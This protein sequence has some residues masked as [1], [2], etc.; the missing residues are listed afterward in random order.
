M[1]IEQ[2][3]TDNSYRNIHYLIACQETGQALAID[4]LEHRNL[5]A[6][7]KYKDVIRRL[8]DYLPTHHEPD[9]PRNPH[10]DLKKSKAKLNR[11]AP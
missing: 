11:L 7:P 9:S 6:D 8:R 3:W 10:N 1:I 4:P 5:A 2:I